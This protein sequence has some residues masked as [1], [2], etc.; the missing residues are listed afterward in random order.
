MKHALLALAVVAALFPAVSGTAGTKAASTSTVVRVT[1]K[2][3]S[4]VLSRKS[5]P[6]GTF[7]FRFTNRGHMPHDFKI[8]GKKTPLVQPGK[9]ATLTV[10][11]LRAGK[12]R[13]ICTVPGHALAGMKGVFTVK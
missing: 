10:K 5:G 13:Y 8:A 12:Y 2:E 7:L 3:Y 4:F 9:S 11:I 6:H 1:G